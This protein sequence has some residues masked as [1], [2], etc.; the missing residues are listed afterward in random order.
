MR[1]LLFTLGCSFLFLVNGCLFG[2]RIAS[3]R[4]MLNFPKER[5]MTE[6]LS[7]NGPEVQDALTYLQTIM[8]SE[9]FSLQAYHSPPLEDGR[10]ADYRGA[11]EVPIRCKVYLRENRLEVLVMETHFSHSGSSPSVEAVCEK[12]GEKLEHRYGNRRVRF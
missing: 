2:D 9:G 1:K 4:I 11:P 7:V 8:S 12:L 5:Q 3:G 10:I 6:A